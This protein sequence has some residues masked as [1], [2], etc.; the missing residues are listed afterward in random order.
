VTTHNT[1]EFSEVVELEISFE[2]SN[3]VLSGK[4]KKK[5]CRGD[6]L[7]NVAHFGRRPLVRSQSLS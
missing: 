6:K 3:I 1:D 2:F 4:Y 5:C 7:S